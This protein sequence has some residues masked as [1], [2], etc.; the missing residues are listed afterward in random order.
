[1]S[2]VAICIQAFVKTKELENLIYSLENSYHTKSLDVFVFVDSCKNMPYK[3]RE[4]WIDKNNSVLRILLDKKKSNTFNKFSFFQNE[5][6]L[7]TAPTCYRAISKCFD[8][9]YDYVIFTEDDTLFTKDAYDF[10]LKQII[11]FQNKNCWAIHGESPFFD[12]K[13]K[14]VSTDL[15][16][17]ISKVVENEN[18]TH[19]ISSMNW[20][21]S[22]NFMI[23]KEK[24]NSYG[25]FRG[26]KMGAIEFGEECKKND[27][28]SVYPIIP[29]V[30]DIGM[31]AADGYSSYF[32]G[33]NVQEIKSTYLTSN[34]FDKNGSEFYWYEGDKNLLFDQT[35]NLN[36]N[37]EVDL[38]P[39]MSEIEKKLLLGSL[40]NKQK[41]IEFGIGGSTKVFLEKGKTVF[42]FETNLEWVEKA[43]NIIQED[44]KK[45]WTI[46]HLDIGKI[47]FL[48][49]PEND[50]LLHLFS[51]QVENIFKALSI[52]S[53]NKETLVFNDGR[54]RVFTQAISFLFF[55]N[56]EILL[57]DYNSERP[58]Y[59]IIFEFSEIIDSSETMYLTK[60]KS[61]ISDKFLNEIIDKFKL[62]PR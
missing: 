38:Q 16:D 35:S 50:N 10:F 19:A 21:N 36:M 28:F 17:Q 37:P 40:D 23:S 33:E 4:D 20:V 43:K 57:H 6:N 15:I 42:S 31:V 5:E 51:V 55:P 44:L 7:G 24:W 52:N 8:L 61:N 3:N 2:N 13:G 62:D 26:K 47:K 12:S 11:R 34:D 54:F 22:T 29:R 18:L 45:K 39:H 32:H 14:K 48:G 41:I 25:T 59:D 60:R 1:M 49:Y 27:G 46:F 9:G 30:V 56:S 53:E 58:H